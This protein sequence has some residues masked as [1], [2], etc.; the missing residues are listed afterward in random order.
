MPY[1]QCGHPGTGPEEAI[2]LAVYMK[3]NNLRCRQVQ[4]FMPTPGTISTAM[5]YTGIDPYTKVPVAVARGHKERARQRALMFWWKREEWPAVREALQTWNRRDLIGMGPDCLVPPGPARG[6][7]QRGPRPGDS[8]GMG[9]QVERA[10][11]EEIDEARWEGLA[12]SA[13]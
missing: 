10:S 1:F 9:M 4:L 13:T 5:Y 3:R 12:G 11:R 6:N 2:E 8:T 7:W